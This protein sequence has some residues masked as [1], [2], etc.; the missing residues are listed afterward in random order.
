M[1]DIRERQTLTKRLCLAALWSR[2]RPRRV[3][4]SCAD[5]IRAVRDDLGHVVGGGWS[6]ANFPIDSGVRYGEH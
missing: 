1:H 5:E 6:L 2:V 3:S 4:L